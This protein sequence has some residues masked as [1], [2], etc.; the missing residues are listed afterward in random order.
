MPPIRVVAGGGA[1]DAV[2][3]RHGVDHSIPLPG[4]SHPDP[5]VKR[6]MKVHVVHRLVRGEPDAVKVAR[7]FGGRARETHRPKGRQGAPARPLR[8]S[9][10]AVERV[11]TLRDDC[12]GS[13]QPEEREAF[14][15]SNHPHVRSRRSSPSLDS[16]DH[17][18]QPVNAVV[19]NVQVDSVLHVAERPRHGERGVVV[20]PRRGHR[21]VCAE[22]GEGELEHGGRASPGHGP[23]P[24]PPR[25]ATTPYPRG[26]A[27]GRHPLPVFGSRSERPRYLPRT[28]ASTTPPSTN[29][30]S[31]N[32][33]AAR[34]SP[35]PR[36]GATDH[37]AAATIRFEVGGQ[38]HCQHAHVVLARAPKRQRRRLQPKPKQRPYC[39]ASHRPHDPSKSPPTTCRYVLRQPPS[40]ASFG[41]VV[42]CSSQPGRPRPNR[43]PGSEQV[44]MPWSVGRH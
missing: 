15:E 38:H 9:Y 24:A 42:R 4:R 19:T 44:P 20:V 23:D 5:L 10:D 8:R 7:P 31:A 25:R 6:G 11:S 16:E 1:S 34:R 35:A 30:R 37:D 32:I 40:A 14:V 18:L 29:P 22:P 2:Q 3:P 21:E 28:A 41:R 26:A 36:R 27:S 17:P 12:L 33:A 43:T 39:L 13:D